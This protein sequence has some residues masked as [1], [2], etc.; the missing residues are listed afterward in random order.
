[1]KI[2][3]LIVAFLLLQSVISGMVIAGESLAQVP[4]RN[5]FKQ[6]ELEQKKPPVPSR[7]DKRSDKTSEPLALRATIVSNHNSKANVGGIIVGIGEEVNGYRLLSVKQDRAVFIYDE[8]KV[9]V[10]VE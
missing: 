8:Q 3:G 9:T 7:E 10:L 1:M 6:M 5:P 2:I 4:K